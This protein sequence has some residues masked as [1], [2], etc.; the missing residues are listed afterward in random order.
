MHFLLHI[1]ITCFFICTVF[2][3]VH[4]AAPNNIHQSAPKLI[5][6]LTSN[7]PGI[8]K[9]TVIELGGLYRHISENEPGYFME[10]D[11]RK[12]LVHALKDPERDVRRSAVKS[13]DSINNLLD[14]P[15]LRSRLIDEQDPRV[16]I[17]LINTLGRFR[18]QASEIRMASFLNDQ[19]IAIRIA[20]IRALGSIGTDSAD[21]LVIA[22][23]NDPIESVCIVAMETCSSNGIKRAIPLLKDNGKHPLSDVRL[24][25]VE[26]MGV[27]GDKSMLKYL[28]KIKKK[29]KDTTVEEAIER[30]IQAINQRL[31][32]EKEE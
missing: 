13:L 17:A 26:T 16:Q 9:N 10:A 15:A 32:A 27:L 8:R 1:L 18:V 25:A 29:E 3:Q 5:K 4:S 28:K 24:T 2:V 21:E 20:A 19:S 6:K 31:S 7:D 30:S 23:I 11:V 14:I 12:A 22:R